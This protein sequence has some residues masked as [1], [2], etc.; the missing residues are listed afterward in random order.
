MQKS[1]KINL[2]LITLLILI[3]NLL[4]CIKKDSE[5][6][7][8]EKNPSKIFNTQL[9]QVCFAYYEDTT[10]NAYSVY[11]S[12]DY[13]YVADGDSGL[14]VIDISDPTDPGS[15][16]YEDTTGSAFDVYVSGDYAYV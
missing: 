5:F 9:P 1:K 2:L 3:P 15:P 4:I 14:A 6:P 10:G 13:V 11:V 12:G 7:F 8:D 16:V